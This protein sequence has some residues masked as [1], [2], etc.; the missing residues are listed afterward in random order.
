MTGFLGAISGLRRTGERG[1]TVM[2]IKGLR[3]VHP[4]CAV[5]VQ[6]ASW[7]SRGPPWHGHNRGPRH[8]SGRDQGHSA[9]KTRWKPVVSETL[10]FSSDYPRELSNDLAPNRRRRV[11]LFGVVPLVVLAAGVAVYW[12][13]LGAQAASGLE[14]ADAK[15]GSQAVVQAQQGSGDAPSDAKPNTGGPP[16]QT[17]QHERPADGSDGSAGAAKGAG[18]DEPVPDPK[19]ASELAA[20][21]HPSAPEA[22]VRQARQLARQGDDKEAERLYRLALSVDRRTHEAAAGMARLRL[23]QGNALNAWHW[24]ERALRI[25]P[26]RAS[27]H[28]LQGDA[29]DKMENRPAAMG[30]WRRALQIDPEHH[31]AQSRVAE[32]GP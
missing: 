1:S 4:Q 6:G 31:G 12:E 32:I 7:H 26:L 9:G 25:R 18:S 16:G 14:G 30:S 3:P 28:V 15:D 29:Y 17:R 13:T 27:Y 21:N 19:L 2:V 24:A 5:P 22:L 8:S 23:R 10:S 11:V 20:G